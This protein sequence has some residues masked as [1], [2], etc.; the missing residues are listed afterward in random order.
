MKKNH[1][2]PNSSFIDLPI[3]RRT[4]FL[5]MIAASIISAVIIFFSELS[6]NLSFE[7]FNQAIT[8]FKVPLGILG[9][10]I[11]L[12]ALLA[13]NHRSEQT[14]E[15][16]RLASENN[17]FSNYFKHLSEFQ[18]HLERISKYSKY[19]ELVNI[20]HFHMKLFPHSK[21][22]NYHASKEETEQFNMIFDEYIE[23]SSEIFEFQDLYQETKKRISTESEDKNKL[24][25]LELQLNDISQQ[26]RSRNTRLLQN[27]SNYFSELSLGSKEGSE[28]KDILPLTERTYPDKKVIAIK[29]CFGI[30]SQA[31]DFDENYKK[32][33]RIRSLIAFNMK[34]EDNVSPLALERIL[35][36]FITKDEEDS[37]H[38]AIDRPKKTN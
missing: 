8:V 22:G 31:F 29:H 18:Q 27:L 7:G 28:I 12:I 16:M 35:V 33:K 21:N 6:L 17:N 23:T 14:K 13:A 26:I 4:I 1:F 2:D 25:N 15:Q 19:I 24:Q 9:V 37:Y 34:I 36:A 11:P 3:L 32:S 10:T 30:I 5:S 38:F 20:R